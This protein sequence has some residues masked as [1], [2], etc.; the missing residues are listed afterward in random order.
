MICS[1]VYL[2]RAISPPSMSY[3]TRRTLFATDTVFGGKVTVC[4]DRLPS[5]ISKMVVS[6]VNRGG[7]YWTVDSTVFEMWLGL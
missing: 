7:P 1:S 6:T 2:F 4:F 5:H 3:F